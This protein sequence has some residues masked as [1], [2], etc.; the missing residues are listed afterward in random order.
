[1]S[2]WRVVLSEQSGKLLFVTRNN[3]DTEDMERVQSEQTK[4]FH[5]RIKVIEDWVYSCD[6]LQSLLNHRDISLHQDINLLCLVY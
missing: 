1:M 5:E 3:H 2:D 6:T 4:L